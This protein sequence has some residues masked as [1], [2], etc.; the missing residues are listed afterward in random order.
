M[1]HLPSGYGGGMR[2]DEV[3]LRVVENNAG[4]GGSFSSRSARHAVHD[5]LSDLSVSSDVIA[6]VELVTSELVTNALLHG[7][8]PCSL[9]LSLSGRL[10]RI[11][12]SDGAPDRLPSLCSSDPRNEGG[13]GL[14]LC[15]DLAE[16][17]GTD[18]GSFN[19]T[20]WAEMTLDR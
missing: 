12:V 1:N 10:L 4:Q 9:T 16:R 18:I 2:T 17:W 19:K 6:D 5:V 20:V 15:G 3:L 7:A 11:E 13:R 8:R 14:R